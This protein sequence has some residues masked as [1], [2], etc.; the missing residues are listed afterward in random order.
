MKNILNAKN[1][2]SSNPKD[3]GTISKVLLATDRRSQTSVNRT[4]N[5]TAV[6]RVM[7]C[8]KSFL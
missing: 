6:R 5:A 3:F 1:Q 2:S 8:Y 4:I 7:L